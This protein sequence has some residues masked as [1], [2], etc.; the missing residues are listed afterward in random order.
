MAQA[1]IVLREE[2]L[3]IANDLKENTRL[4]SLTEVVGVLLTRYGRHLKATW[5]LEPG[6]DTMPEV[7]STP[8]AQPVTLPE[9]STTPRDPGTHLAPLWS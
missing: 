9:Q 3:T 1:R 4:G 5:E 6:A 7:P 2:H 8:T